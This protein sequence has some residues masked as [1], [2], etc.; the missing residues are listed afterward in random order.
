MKLAREVILVLKVQPVK[1]VH[2]VIVVL[3]VL[4][5]QVEKEQLEDKERLLESQSAGPDGA[6]HRLKMA[7]WLQGGTILEDPS[8]K[9]MTM[10]PPREWLK[11]NVSPPPQSSSTRIS[12]GELPI[13]MAQ[14]IMELKALPLNLSNTESINSAPSV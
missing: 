9:H 13:R 14:R 8:M 7:Q 2:K 6:P 1:K 10:T 12:T 5:V 4:I 3:K 11:Y